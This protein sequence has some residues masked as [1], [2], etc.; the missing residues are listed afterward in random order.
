M[1]NINFKKNI[2][3]ILL[4]SLGTGLEYYDFVIYG[5][6]ACYM[7]ELFFPKTDSFISV[8]QSFSIFSIGYIIRPLGGL[9]FGIIGDKYGRKITFN[10]TM[11]LMT[12]SSTMISLLPTY[13]S[14][15]ATSTFLLIFF[16]IIQGIAFGAEMPGAIT[17]INESSERK[18]FS[19]GILMIPIGIGD[20]LASSTVFMLTYFLSKKSIIDWGW[21]IPFLLSSIL[22]IISFSARKIINET[23]EFKKYIKEE[24]DNRLT[25]SKLFLEINWFRI[26][27][28]I[29]ISLTGSYL[30]IF[31]IYMPMYFSKYFQY[32]LETIYFFSII[33]GIA[34]IILA[35]ILGYGSDFIGSIRSL[36][37]HVIILSISSFFLFHLLDTNNLI[38]AGTLIIMSQIISYSYYTSLLVILG[39]LFPI[40]IRYTSISIC[41]NISYCISSFIFII[42]PYII[43]STKNKI[44]PYW[45]L[46]FMCTLTLITCLYYKKL[47]RLK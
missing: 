39:D 13:N 4:I 29:L 45:L 35:P 18:G 15:G 44:S 16:R 37:I 21:R 5:F 10:V 25:I 46:L 6:M 12:I 19:F 26:I 14:I 1:V 31:N 33:G 32:N 47:K 3:S 43:E 41:Y 8:M 28:G 11:L 27:I 34:A 38:F 9:I 22:G 7:N 2:L 23:P 24:I 20:I 36:I 17:Y 40:H 30:V 42:I